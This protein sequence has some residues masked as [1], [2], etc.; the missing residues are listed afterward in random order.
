MS[1]TSRPTR[2]AICLEHLPLVAQGV[3]VADSVQDLGVFC[4]D[5]P[6]LLFAARADWRG[7]LHVGEKLI[8]RAAVD[9]RHRRRKFI[10]AV[11]RGAESVAVFVEVLL[12]PA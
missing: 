7:D 11:A 4:D 10:E 9:S 6:C 5:A 3:L 1:F 2:P 12:P 8:G